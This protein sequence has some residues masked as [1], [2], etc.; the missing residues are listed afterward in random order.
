MGNLFDT[1]MR[2]VVFELSPETYPDTT[3]RTFYINELME[4]EL[5][6]VMVR[7]STSVGYSQYT[8]ARNIRTTEAGWY[9]LFV[10]L[11]LGIYKISVHSILTP[12]IRDDFLYFVNE[13]MISFSEM[14]HITINC[15]YS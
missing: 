9:S 10:G 1:V 7:V 4:Y 6:S 3:V 5:Y 15:Y 12:L 2:E 14:K 8:S 13:K 11:R